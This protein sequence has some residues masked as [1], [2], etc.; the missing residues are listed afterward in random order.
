[1]S[2]CHSDSLA[3]IT[4]LGDKNSTDEENYI[5]FYQEQ[6]NKRQNRKLSYNEYCKQD[7]YV[8]GYLTTV[9]QAS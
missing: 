6:K 1:M 9:S 4:E 7:I 5:K 2:N 8:T 3:I